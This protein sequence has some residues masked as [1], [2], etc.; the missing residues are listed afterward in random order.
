MTVE[1]G[2]G[3][4]MLHKCSNAAFMPDVESGPCKWPE[5]RLS[6]MSATATALRDLLGTMPHLDANPKVKEIRDV[7]MLFRR[8]F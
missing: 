4:G 5:E 1:L 2:R 3:D 6:A 8:A 7:P